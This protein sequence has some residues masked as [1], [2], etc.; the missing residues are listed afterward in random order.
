MAIIEI[1]LDSNVEIKADDPALGRIT[2][3]FHR[4]DADMRKLEMPTKKFHAALDEYLSEKDASGK[5][6]A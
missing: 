5:A 2:I 4:A 3:Y 6:P 1:E